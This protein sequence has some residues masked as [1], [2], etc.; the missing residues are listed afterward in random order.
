[1]VVGTVSA[2]TQVDRDWFGR[3]G[4]HECDEHATPNEILLIAGRF[5]LSV[6]SSKEVAAPDAER[7]SL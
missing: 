1:M 3:K 4:S 7:S 6:G 2:Y 5:R